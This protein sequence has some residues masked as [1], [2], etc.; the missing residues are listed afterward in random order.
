[1]MGGDLSIEPAQTLATVRGALIDGEVHVVCTG[2]GASDIVGVALWFPPGHTPMSSLVTFL[3]S[4]M[5]RS[6]D[7]C[8][9]R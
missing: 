4:N 8:I 9:K 6:T 5:G 2:P 7:L 3:C 1:M